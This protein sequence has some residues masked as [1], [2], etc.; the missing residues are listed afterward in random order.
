MLKGNLNE[1]KFLSESLNYNYRTKDSSG[2]PTR[3]YG[4]A[5]RS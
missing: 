1:G 2:K 5:K 3:I 4:T